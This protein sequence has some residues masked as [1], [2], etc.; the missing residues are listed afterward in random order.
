MKKSLIQIN[1]LS[2]KIKQNKREKI[3]KKNLI[4]IKLKLM[5]KMKKI[6]QEKK[7]KKH[8]RIQKKLKIIYRIFNKYQLSVNQNI[9]KNEIK[10]NIK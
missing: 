9:L 1:K 5:K 4:R 10:K 8:W 6:I 3:L 7:A 2:K